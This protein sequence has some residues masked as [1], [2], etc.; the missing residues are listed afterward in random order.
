MELNEHSEMAVNND[1]STTSG[2]GENTLQPTDMA[3]E[4]TS[5]TL[6]VEEQPEEIDVTTLN[7]AQLSAYF[8][9]LV[10][11]F[12]ANR[13]QSLV[14]PIKAQF[15]KLT[16]GE[17]ATLKAKFLAD[18]GTDEDFKRQ[19]DEHDIEFKQTYQSYKA[20]RHTEHQHEE[21]EREDNLEKKALIIEKLRL[22]SEA[23]DI[24]EDLYD[25]FHTLQK[26]WKE[27]GMVP[28]AQ[29]QNLYASYNLYVD[30]IYAYLKINRELRELDLKKNY[31]AKEALCQ[32][33]EQLAN[34]PLAKKAFA[35]LQTLHE[36]WREI[37][38]VAKALR[39]EIWD[40]FRA[41]TVVVNTKFHN[42]CDERQ[43]RSVK[44]YEGK[45]AL[46]KQVSDISSS[47]LSTPKEWDEA[48]KQIVELQ[49]KWK[50]IGFVPKM[51]NTQVFEDFRKVCNDF[52][53]NKRQFFKNYKSSQSA[54]LEAKTLLCMQAE[55]L[56]DNTDWKKTAD[57]LIQIQKKWKEIGPVPMSQADEI[58]K[59]FRKACDTFFNKKAEHF[60][61]VE[62]TQEENLKK[63]QEIIE[64]LKSIEMPE[65]IDA[66][67]VKIQELQ[68]RWNS[69]GYVPIK[70]KE[71]I[72]QEYGKLINELYDKMD[73]D[74][75]DKNI[76]RF[77]SRVDS[78]K[79]EGNDKLINERN[80]LISKLKQIESD[81]TTWEN[82]IGFFAKSKK[83][84]SLIADFN[85]K[86][87]TAKQ[88][89]VMM[90]KKLDMIDELLK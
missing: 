77:K 32:A 56:M 72:T 75:L 37:G 81:I 3:T 59:R 26:E 14:E 50:E 17:T 58:W 85:H 9:K 73:I 4:A 15:E 8:K 87:A 5:D 51:Y 66:R 23:P 2:N 19:E 53:E 67:I 78:L 63:K 54:N 48:G 35:E 43:E 88:N 52:F 65:D 21:Q 80:K 29:V 57:T 47:K 41:A 24:V 60:G 82:N 30:Q 38:P 71:P 79:S 90:N 13:I 46:I 39:E 69:I 76:Q 84:D 86:I 55:T 7:R 28:G 36:Q 31:D 22:I 1:Q 68:K 74:E 34:E 83:S 62:G 40:R 16:H 25:Q 89:I 64:E 10:T 11:N 20:A 49:A 44:N 61:A 45:L 42:Y 12:K 33:A 6:A 18:G 27:I 70:S